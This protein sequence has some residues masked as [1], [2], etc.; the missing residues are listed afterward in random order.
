LA[1]ENEVYAGSGLKIHNFYGA[2]ECGGI[3]WDASE[4]P[5]DSAS[6]VGMPLPGVAVTIGR[7]GRLQVTS[8][9]VASGYDCVREEDG[10]GD[11]VYLTRDLGYLNDTGEIH[12]T[13]TLGGAINVSGR[14]V[15]PAKVEAGLLATG[16][17]RRVRVVG[18]ASADP[19]RV[20]EIS[21]EVVLAPGATLERVKAAALDHLQGWEVPR[22]WQVHL[23]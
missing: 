17:V 4:T 21:A 19:E 7:E 6:G 1:L 8:D 13:G 5:R 2:S 14:K 23:G 10:L 12:L 15:S 16:W 18:R 22:H 11:G 3:S 9:A 20:A